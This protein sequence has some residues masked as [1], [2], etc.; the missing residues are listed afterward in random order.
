M[1]IA[2]NKDNLIEGA[3]SYFFRRETTPFGGYHHHIAAQ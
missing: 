2:S 3:L 1:R